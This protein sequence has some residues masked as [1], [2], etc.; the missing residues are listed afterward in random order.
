MNISMAQFHCMLN[1]VAIVGVSHL[2]IESDFSTKQLRFGL[3]CAA[4]HWSSFTIMESSQSKIKL[5]R[6]LQKPFGILGIFEPQQSQRHPFNWQNFVSLIFLGLYS[7][8]CGVFFLVEATT[9]RQYADSF[10]T[11]FSV[12]IPFFTCS[13]TISYVAQIYELIHGF[14][15]LIQKRENNFR[16]ID[17]IIDSLWKR[18]FRSTFQVLIIRRRRWFMNKH[19]K[20]SKNYRAAFTLHS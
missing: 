2:M 11:S 18:T 15:A 10:Y 3:F 5:F 8:S 12:G 19:I 9:F 13:T 14:E 17:Q 7:A 6:L 16:L 20:M 4:E 1:R